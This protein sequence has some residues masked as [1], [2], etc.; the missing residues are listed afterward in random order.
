[1]VNAALID[2]VLALAVLSVVTSI[3]LSGEAPTPARILVTAGQAIV[4][5]F[6][7]LIVAVQ[8][9]PRISK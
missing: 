1:M 7:M 4:I 2:D 9:L 8:V 5:W 3:V 6:V